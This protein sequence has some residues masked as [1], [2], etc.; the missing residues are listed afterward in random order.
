M[1]GGPNEDIRLDEN[2]DEPSRFIVETVVIEPPEMKAR[3]RVPLL[4][5]VREFGAD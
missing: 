4:K 1:I 3:L 5:V 2:L